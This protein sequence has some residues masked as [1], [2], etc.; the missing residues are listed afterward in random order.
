[1]PRHLIVRLE[2]PLMAFGGETIDNY[3]VIRPFPAKSMITGLL[4]NALGYGR[5]EAD[6]LAEL[7]ARII[8]GARIDR[9]GTKMRDFQTAELFE[10]DAGWT[11][12]ARPEGRKKSP[13]YKM[14]DGHRRLTWR[15]YRDYHCDA[16]LHVALRLEPAEEQ[17]DL[18]A[19]AHALDAP[20]RPLFIGRKPCLP[21]ERLFA[22]FIQA[23]NVHEALRRVSC[24][25]SQADFAGDSQWPE[26]E[27]PDGM[28]QGFHGERI[29]DERNWLSGLHGGDR[30]IVTGRV[31]PTI[32]GKTS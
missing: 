15:R 28:S 2:A 27:G 23:D 17:P 5:H 16:L 22:G 7:Q 14:K 25:V 20:A 19:L 4:A 8:M 32:G 29:C 26:G 10:G 13:S 30:A 18:D 24:A 9:A 12:R 31:T 21:A 11:T 1:M 3:G 6:K